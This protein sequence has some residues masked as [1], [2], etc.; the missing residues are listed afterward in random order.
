[1][2]LAA[3]THVIEH[4]PRPGEIFIELAKHMAVDGKIYITAPFRPSLWQPEQGFEPWLSYPY[5]HVPA[6]LSYLSEKWMRT[7][8]AR[9]GFE[10]IRWDVSLDGYQ[11]FEAI[12][13]KL[14]S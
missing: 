8:A 7:M 12:L 3:M 11:V 6:H 13:R 9:S 2:H 4:L 5:L 14:K 10:V 1:M